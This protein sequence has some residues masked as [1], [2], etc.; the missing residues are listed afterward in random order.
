MSYKRSK[1]FLTSNKTKI[2]YFFL[3]KK[4]QITIVFFHG[5]MSDMVGEKPMIVQKFCKREKINFLK[6]EYSGHGKS[7]GKFIKGNISKWTAEAK[8]LISSKV[9]KKK[10]DNFCWLKYGKLDCFKLIFPF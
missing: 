1:Y 9:K 6:F 2:K 4:S 3:N 10:Q 5:F 8:Q 7:T